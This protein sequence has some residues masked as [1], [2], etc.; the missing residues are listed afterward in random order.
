MVSNSADR[1]KNNGA[2]VAVK[3]LVKRYEEGRDSILDGITFAIEPSEF[4]IVHGRSG[5]GKTTLLNILGGLDRP[6]SGSVSVDGQSMIGLSEDELA[7]MRLE[8]IGFVFQ[9]CNLLMDLT[10]RENVAVPR[11]FSKKTVKR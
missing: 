9:D 1:S 2:T 3:D 6:T 7:R 8:K 11:S 5:C 4:V 10:V